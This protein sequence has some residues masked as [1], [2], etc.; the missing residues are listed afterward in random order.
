M[1]PIRIKAKNIFLTGRNLSPD[2]LPIP[3]DEFIQG[4]PEDQPVKIKDLIKH[5]FP[6]PLKLIMKN[7]EIYAGFVIAARGQFK[8][9]LM[10]RLI[11][12]GGQSRR[13]GQ[14]EMTIMDPDVNI[15]KIFLIPPPFKLKPMG[16]F[17]EVSGQFN[18]GLPKLEYKKKISKTQVINIKANVQSKTKLRREKQMVTG[19]CVK[20]RRQVEME[21][22][23]IGKTSRGVEMRKGKCPTC[24]TT[25]C[26]IGRIK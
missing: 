20:C 17:Y 14:S 5:R 7:K 9:I 25:V 10:S 6:I 11:G 12:F 15:K 21:D 4:L 19:Y 2:C 22:I 24:N 3:L 23:V 13:F 18:K 1:K 16:R 26:R 8:F